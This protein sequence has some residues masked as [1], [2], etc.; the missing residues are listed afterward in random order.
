[1]DRSGIR[2]RKELE[3]FSDGRCRPGI[4]GDKR[5]MDDRP[6]CLS[7]VDANNVVV[8]DFSVIQPQFWYVARRLRRP[9][10]FQ[11]LTLP[12]KPTTLRTK[13]AT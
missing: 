13:I 8:K 1:M 2:I 10:T 7:L 11:G 5:L 3:T 6:M 9:L 12:F 4:C